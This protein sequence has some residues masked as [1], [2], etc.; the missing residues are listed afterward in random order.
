MNYL[1]NN[2]YGIHLILLYVSQYLSHSI[3]GITWSICQIACWNT[4]TFSI[5]HSISLLSKLLS[6]LL[7]HGLFLQCLCKIK[8]RRN[9]HLSHSRTLSNQLPPKLC[10]CPNTK[11]RSKHRSANFLCKRPDSQYFRLCGLRGLCHSLI[12]EQKQPKTVLSTKQMGVAAIQWTFTKT[13][14]SLF[15]PRQEFADPCINILVLTYCQWSYLEYL[16]VQ[17]SL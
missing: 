14:R 4:C 13:S 11:D 16:K 10:L 5:L 1:E 8:V 9:I 3:I 17:R 12:I 2:I 15:G 6:Q 7:L